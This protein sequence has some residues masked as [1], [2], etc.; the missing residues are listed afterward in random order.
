MLRQEKRSRTETVLKLYVAMDDDRKAL[1]P[2]LPAKPLPRDPRGGVSTLSAAEVLTVLGWG[3]WRGLT[4]Q[5]K[6]SC[7]LQT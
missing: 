6:L 4:D 7:H 1:R 3:A 5:A 2:H